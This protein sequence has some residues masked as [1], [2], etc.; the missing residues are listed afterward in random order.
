MQIF[1][2]CKF[3]KTCSICHKS[4]RHHLQLD[5]FIQVICK[6]RREQNGISKCYKYPYK[7]LALCFSD[8]N[9]NNFQFSE[10]K[11]SLKTWSSRN[12]K[13]WSSNMFLYTEL[14][15]MRYFHYEG[16]KMYPLILSVCI[17]WPPTAGNENSGIRLKKLMDTLHLN[18]SVKPPGL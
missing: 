15:L 6:Y 16:L 10:N 13:F 3:Y 17:F 7:V 1:G 14:I 8:N 11:S 5:D 4:F 18:F 2:A 12:L 9:N